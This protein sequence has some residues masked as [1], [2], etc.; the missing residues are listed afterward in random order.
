MFWLARGSLRDVGISCLQRRGKKEEASNGGL[1]GYRL[2]V[3]S[4]DPGRRE[5]KGLG[6]GAND[7]RLREYGRVSIP[8]RGT[9][10]PYGARGTQR[11]TTPANRQPAPSLEKG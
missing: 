7:D 4:D 6:N 5:R 11:R 2:L 1:C 8:T 10:P 3:R 9:N